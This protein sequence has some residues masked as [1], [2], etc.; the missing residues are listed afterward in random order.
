MN[1]RSLFVRKT[2]KTLIQ[3]Y[4]SL[5]FIDVFTGNTLLRHRKAKIVSTNKL[6][7]KF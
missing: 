1:Q 5:S 7:A 4:V 2:F 6:I 3:N